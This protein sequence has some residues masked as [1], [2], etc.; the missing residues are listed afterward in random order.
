VRVG[1]IFCLAVTTLAGC[2][3]DGLNLAPVEGVVTLDGTP[4]GD[5]GVVFSPVDPAQGPPASGATNSQGHFTL[6]TNN[7]EG[8]P[9]GEHKVTISKADP[10]GEQVSLEQ[11][12]DPDF[13]RRRG[14]IVFKTKHFLPPKYADITSSELTAT[15][16]D[17]DNTFQFDL[18][19]K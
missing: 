9:I 15:V 17:T 12:E 13:V 3:G 14:R 4:V 19:A 2:G 16:E 1:T 11:L 5:A 6:M 8:A 18:S 7:R 10:F